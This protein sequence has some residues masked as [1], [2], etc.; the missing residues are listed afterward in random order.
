LQDLPQEALQ[1]LSQMMW[2]SGEGLINLN[3]G[4]VY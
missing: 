4:E 2:Y 1:S 3:T